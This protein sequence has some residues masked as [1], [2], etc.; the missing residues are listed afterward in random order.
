[1]PGSPGASSKDRFSHDSPGL[2]PTLGLPGQAPQGC[3]PGNREVKGWTETN[4]IVMS[5][6]T[7]PVELAKGGRKGWEQADRNSAWLQ[8]HVPEIYSQHRGKCIC[9]A[10]GEPFVADTPEEVFARAKASATRKTKVFSDPLHPESEK[11]PRIYATFRT[12]ASL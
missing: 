5:E 6:V 4:S 11:R 9:V 3:S 10:G 7:D 12:V 1:M 2:F 8:A